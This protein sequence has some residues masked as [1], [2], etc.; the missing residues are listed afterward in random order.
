M[1]EIIKLE[2]ELFERLGYLLMPTDNIEKSLI[3]NYKHNRAGTDPITEL[4]LLYLRKEYDENV[5]NIDKITVFFSW[6]KFVSTTVRYI[7][8]IDILLLNKTEDVDFKDIVYHKE[9][10]KYFYFKIIRRDYYARF[11]NTDRKGKS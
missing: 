7:E 9:C 6:K 8:T 4:G 3:Y 5:E 1:A 11:N 10:D 2:K